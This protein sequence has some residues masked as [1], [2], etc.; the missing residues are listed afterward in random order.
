LYSIP[1]IALPVPEV[2]D[3][4]ALVVL[5]VVVETVLVADKG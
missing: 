5:V 4:V 3:L 1:A 2:A